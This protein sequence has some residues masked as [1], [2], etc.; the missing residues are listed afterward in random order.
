MRLTRTFESARP[1]SFLI[2]T[3]DGAGS[4]LT[5]TNRA[6]VN[7]ARRAHI[8]GDGL[9]DS[10]CPNL[11]VAVKRRPIVRLPNGEVE[12][13]RARARLEPRVHTVFPHPRRHYRLSR[14]P[15]T[16]V[17]RPPRVRACLTCGGVS[18]L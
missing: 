9:A 6:S 3:S 17:R 11:A 15:P 2:R 8:T 16:I 13:P 12:G 1:V 14:T 4:G 7:A 18:H 5:Q 10:C